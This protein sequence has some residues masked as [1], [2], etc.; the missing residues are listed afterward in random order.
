MQKFLGILLTFLML[1]A[2]TPVALVSPL[3]ASAA[4]TDTLNFNITCDDENEVTKNTGEIIT[5]TFTMENATEETASFPISSYQNE[6]Y[7]DHSFFEAVEDSA[8]IVSGVS[9]FARFDAYSWGEHRV[10]FN[11]FQISTVQYMA[12]QVIGTCQLKIIATEGSSTLRCVDDKMFAYYDG[13]AYTLT[14]TDLVV[15]VG[16]STSQG[17]EITFDANGG[18]GVMSAVGGISG[19]YTLPDCTF[20]APAGKQFMGWATSAGGEI[21][22]SLDATENVTLY[23]IWETL[24]HTHNF[25]VL[26]Y[27]E[28]QHWHKCDGCSEIDAKEN[29]KDG[30]ATCLEKAE[31]S[32]CQQPYGKKD[33]NNHATSTFIYYPN[34]DATHTKKYECCG[35]VVVENEAHT[36]DNDNKCICGAE[37]TTSQ[38]D[39]DDS[40]FWWLWI[41]ILIILLIIIILI[42]C[43]IDDN[44]DERKRRERNRKGR[45]RRYR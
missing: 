22:T 19:S 17:Y 43:F 34:D 23:A 24:D 9:G 44:D 41:I 20:N 36:W 3:T 6:I 18:T 27:D 40:S 38:P 29:H 39:E 25:T 8:K 4:S 32:V 15:N 21:I 30:T 11:G 14:K 10:F 42:I 33:A 45:Y 12:K 13:N 26:K 35:L 37:S 31:C 7:Y 16:D 28:E 1:F 2:V 5:V